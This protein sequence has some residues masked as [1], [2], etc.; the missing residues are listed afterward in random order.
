[1]RVRDDGIGMQA[2][3]AP[4]TTSFGIVGIKER[5][6]SLG[7]EFAIDGSSGQGTLLSVFIP[8]DNSVPS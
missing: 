3:A 4:K 1:M 7:G 6:S 8:I 5:I 2:D